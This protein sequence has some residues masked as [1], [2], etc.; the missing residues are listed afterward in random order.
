MGPCDYVPWLQD[1]KFAEIRLEGRGFGDVPM[2][3][4]LKLEVVDSPNSAGIV[5]DAVR[6]CRLAIDNGLSGALEGPSSYLMKSPPVQYTDNEARQ[7]TESFIERET[8]RRA[9][10]APVEMPDGSGVPGR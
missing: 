8:A 7:L 3:I 6:I 9:A 1:R 4:N 2:Q 10:E 5:I